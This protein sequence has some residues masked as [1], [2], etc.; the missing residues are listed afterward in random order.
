MQGLGFG[1]RG[2]G[3]TNKWYRL[4]DFPCVIAFLV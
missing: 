4:E 2:L 1:G 3:F